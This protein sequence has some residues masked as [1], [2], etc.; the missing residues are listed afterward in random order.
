MDRLDNADGL[1]LYAIKSKQEKMLIVGEQGLIRTSNDGG[2][3]FTSLDAPYSG[4]FFTTQL[5]A[6][7]S[8]FVA[9]MRGNAWT[10]HKNGEWEKLMTPDTTSI[11]GSALQTD[12][13]VVLVNQA[14]SLFSAH[15]GKFSKI[16][17]NN[18]APLNAV[19]ALNND[20][21]LIGQQ[22]P[23]FM[24]TGGVNGE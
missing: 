8:L 23:L 4:S 16:I 2:R 7:G 13:T 1:H 22:L 24:N 10:M 15:G 9:G 11:T 18:R 14:G 6:D 19:L 17:L 21:L 3:H 20:N 5:T 12:N